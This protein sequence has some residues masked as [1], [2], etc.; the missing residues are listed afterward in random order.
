MKGLDKMIGNGQSF[1]VWYDPW[2]RDGNLRIPL[3]KNIFI[4]LNLKVSD[5]L[6]QV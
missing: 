1:N 6:D 5:L 2:I 4:N 3:M